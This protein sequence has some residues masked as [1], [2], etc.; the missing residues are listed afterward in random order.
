MNEVEKSVKV[1]EEQVGDATVQTKSV[2]T[3]ADSSSRQS[4][5]KAIQIIYYIAGV[6]SLIIGVRLLLVL[7]GA[8]S[9]GV[10]NFVYQVTEPFVSPFYGIFGKTIAYGASRLELESILAIVTVGVITFI[11]VGFVRLLK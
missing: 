11:I 5:N 6:L 7:F 9:V 4:A 3:S 10:V 1:E 8:R 2:E